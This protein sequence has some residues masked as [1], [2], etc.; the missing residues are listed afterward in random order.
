MWA[1]NSTRP[2]SSASFHRQTRPRAN[3]QSGSCYSPPL[4]PAA[5][6]AFLCRDRSYSGGDPFCAHSRPSTAS[7]LASKQNSMRSLKEGCGLAKIEYIRHYYDY[8]PAE[9]GF[10]SKL[11]LNT[12]C[13]HEKSRLQDYV[14]S[15]PRV[16]S[17]SGRERHPSILCR[18]TQRSPNL[19]ISTLWRKTSASKPIIIARD[20]IWTDSSDHRRKFSGAYQSP[21]RPYRREQPKRTYQDL[22]LWPEHQ[23]AAETGR[24][25]YN[26][27]GRCIGHR[28][29]NT[30]QYIV[31]T[32]PR[33][34]HVEMLLSFQMHDSPPKA[35]RRPEQG[36]KSA[37]NVA[38]SVEKCRTV[39]ERKEPVRVRNDSERAV[40]VRAKT[41]NKNKRV[42]VL[43]KRPSN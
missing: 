22:S 13:P 39:D 1:R 30:M 42:T 20:R 7:V 25:E 9:E 10:G 29:C 23:S 16:A 15:R 17:D 43:Q 38:E 12:S 24:D 3:T 2:R 36:E 21:V 35:Y 37:K 34:D 5:K 19:H 27:V 32:E 14:M 11:S 33:E 26:F 31:R 6:Y 28:R 18:Q 40:A 41:A 8:Q 4:R